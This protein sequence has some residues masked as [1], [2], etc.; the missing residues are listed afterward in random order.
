MKRYKVTDKEG[1]KITYSGDDSILE[2]IPSLGHGKPERWQLHKDEPMAESYDE[3]DVLEERID[4]LQPAIDAVMEL[5]SPA[6]PAVDAVL[7]EQGVEIS[8]A[9]PAVDAVYAEVSPAVP[10]VVQTWVKL[11]AEYTVEIVDLEQ[12]PEWLLAQCISK[13]KAEYPTAEEFLNAFFDGG[14]NA[15]DELQAAR[16]AIKAKYPKP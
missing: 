15:I 10:A 13:R 2:K 11:K 16:L 8:P 1:L 3:A 5:V 4:V 14:Q 12:D 6:I 7:D 9:V